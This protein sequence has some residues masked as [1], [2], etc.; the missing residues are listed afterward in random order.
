MLWVLFRTNMKGTLEA[1]FFHSASAF[2]FPVFF[3]SVCLSVW[4]WRSCLSDSEAAAHN[5]WQP[6]MTVTGHGK[7]LCKGPDSQN[8]AG[9]GYHDRSLRLLISWT[10]IRVKSCAR[11]CCPSRNHWFQPQITAE[12]HHIATSQH[13]SSPS[14]RSPH[15]HFAPSATSHEAQEATETQK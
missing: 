11:S 5:W 2:S 15:M 3:I 13:P 12:P 1:K 14:H 9:H 6:L 8:T 4:H 10:E 7:S